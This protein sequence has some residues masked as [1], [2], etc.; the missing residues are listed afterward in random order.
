MSIEKYIEKGWPTDIVKQATAIYKDFNRL[1]RAEN[2]KNV[3]NLCLL[4]AATKHT[5]ADFKLQEQVLDLITTRPSTLSNPYPKYI[6]E[7]K[8]SIA[9]A[10]RKVSNLPTRFS[11]AVR[12]KRITRAAEILA[13]DD[14]HQKSD[15][16]YWLLAEKIVDS[17]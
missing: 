2:R 16:D 12:H 8:L 17:C 5:L 10:L 7:F 6:K 4:L 15:L 13:A 9:R 14:N 1:F 3:M 11:I